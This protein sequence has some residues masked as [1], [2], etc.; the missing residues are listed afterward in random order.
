[1][2]IPLLSEI[3]GQKGVYQL[4]DKFYERQGVIK[5]DELPELIDMIDVTQDIFSE[6]NRVGLFVGT[7]DG[8][9]ISPLGTKVTLLLKAV[10]EER[11]LSKV[12]R[13]LTYLYPE[14]KPY[15]LLTEDITGY[16]IDSLL[17]NP[18]FIRIYICSPWIRLDQDHLEKIKQAFSKA[19]LKYENL[20]ILVIT[21]PREAYNNWK[22]S[23]ETFKVLKD[24]GAKIVINKK[25]HAKLYINEPGPYGGIHYAIFG[26]ENLT[27]R[28]NI[29]LAMK[30]E[31]DNEILNKLIRFFFEIQ[32]ESKILEEV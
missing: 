14:L 11:G 9:Y 26:S 31:N 7:I 15:E 8:F 18:T 17:L 20:E 4:L 6:L 5:S 27:G 28:R 25:L 30:V 16:F 29:E 2:P 12:F 24:L 21:K 13:E 22:G 1:M 19:K 32:E 3:V 23:E 10:N